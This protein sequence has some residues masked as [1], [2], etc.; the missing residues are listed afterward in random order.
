MSMSLHPTWVK[1]QSISLEFGTI[2][3]FKAIGDK[4]GTFMDVNGYFKVDASMERAKG[5]VGKRDKGV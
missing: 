3:I 1:M 4:L 5:L 2:E